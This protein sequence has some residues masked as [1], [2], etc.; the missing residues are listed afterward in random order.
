MERSARLRTLRLILAMTGSAW[1]I[2][3]VAVVLPWAIAAD[4]LQR[5][6]GT[7]PIPDDPMADYWLR[8]AG[9]V[10]ALFGGL[11]LLAAWRPRRFAPIIPILAYASL[12]EGLVLLVHG[13]RL[14]LPPMT[15]LADLAICFAGGIGILVFRGAVPEAG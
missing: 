1:A 14:H 6:G 3:V 4:W 11:F 8:M 7:G 10:F 2:S 13:I 9:S 15:F 5:L 12:F